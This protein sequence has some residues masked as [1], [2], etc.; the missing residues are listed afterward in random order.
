[1]QVHKLAS[2]QS[3]LSQLDIPSSSMRSP[4]TPFDLQLDQKQGKSRSK[5]VYYYP[6]AQK[7]KT[8]APR[9]PK[10]SPTLVLTERY[11]T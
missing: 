2:S 11:L 1:M 4:L 8:T 7:A 10:W 6:R 9:I 5:H 3:I